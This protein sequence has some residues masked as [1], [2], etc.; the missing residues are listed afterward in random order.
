MRTASPA[1]P[2]SPA[3][4]AGQHVSLGLLGAA[5]FIV[6]AN[7]RTIDPLLP[8]IAAEFDTNVGRTALIVTAYAVPYGLCQL[9]Y[10]P[11]GDRLGKLRVMTAALAAFA[12][13]TATCAI[14]PNLASLAALRVLTG[15]AAAALIPLSLAYIGDHFPYDQRQAALGRY[16]GA[17]ALGQMLGAGLGG[18]FGDY[19]SWRGVFL[20]YAL[21][22]LGAWAVLWRASSQAARAPERVASPD[23]PDARAPGPYR[24]LLGDPAARL[25][26]GAVFVEGMFLFSGLAYLGALLRERYGLPYVTIGLMLAGFGLGGLLYSRVAGRLVRRLGE[27]G[28]IFLGGGLSGACYLAMALSRSW[29]LFIP[30]NILLGLGYNLLHGTLQTK[31]TELAPEA[32]GTAVALFAFSLFLGQGL[33]AAVLGAVVDGAGYAVTFIVTGLATGLLAIGLGWAVGREAPRPSRSY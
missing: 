3:E 5:A 27:Q 31:A 17:I 12:L 20:L 18:I 22:A 2:L 9:G 13:G 19:F 11:L 14:A 10:G 7:V 32:R 28:M 8:V 33:G 6:T 1:A 24:R 4:P 29:P 30:L 23:G 21:I 16:L 15:A 26:L 25:I